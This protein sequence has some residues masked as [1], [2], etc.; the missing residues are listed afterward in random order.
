MPDKGIVEGEP[1]GLEVGGERR[2]IKN[3]SL[4]FEL[5]KLKKGEVIY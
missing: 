2:G 1:I 3:D 5:S 4:S